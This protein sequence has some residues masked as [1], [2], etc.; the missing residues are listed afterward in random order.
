[1]TLLEAAEYLV[2]SGLTKI[3]SGQSFLA[4][5]PGIADRFG[6]GIISMIHIL[7]KY[8]SYT[9]VFPR[10]VTRGCQDTFSDTECLAF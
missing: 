8:G 4:M 3:N 9:T 7:H 6:A 10:F 5:Y 1:M 2:K